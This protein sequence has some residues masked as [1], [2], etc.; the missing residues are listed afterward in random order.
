VSGTDYVIL[1][2][3]FIEAYYTLFDVDNMR[4]GFACDGK[5]TGGSW[6][7]SGGFLEVTRPSTWME[8]AFLT[9][10]VLSLVCIVYLVFH[11][12]PWANGRYQG[13]RRIHA[14]GGDKGSMAVPLTE[15][16]V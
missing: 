7:G 9:S 13:Y 12:M 8:M 1:G 3:T 15:A 16:S 5:C 14:Q 4:V 2:D 6:H 10:M 11:L